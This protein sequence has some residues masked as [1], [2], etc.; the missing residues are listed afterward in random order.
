MN[1]RSGNKKTSG[2]CDF[3][4]KPLKIKG[5]KLDQ[6]GIKKGK[7]RIPAFDLFI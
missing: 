2:M 5:L 4:K 6:K 3:R 1:R 7:R